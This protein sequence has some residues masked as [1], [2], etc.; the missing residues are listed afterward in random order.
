MNE[1]AK[2]IKAKR[3]NK[4]QNETYRHIGHTM[5]CDSNKYVYNTETEH[6]EQKKIQKPF[7][8]EEKNQR[9]Q[10]Y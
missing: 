1:R 10:L 4:K 2:A 3:K 7:E 6:R 9:H 5:E 8:R